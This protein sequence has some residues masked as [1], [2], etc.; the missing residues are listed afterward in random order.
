M[1]ENCIER[2]KRLNTEK[3]IADFKVKQKV[4]LRF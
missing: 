4:R 3:K 1:A 2:N